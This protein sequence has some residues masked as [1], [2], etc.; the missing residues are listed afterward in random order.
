MLYLPE[1]FTLI[2]EVKEIVKARRIRQIWLVQ[3]CHRIGLHVQGHGVN[4]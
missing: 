3:M 4:F 1:H 2:T